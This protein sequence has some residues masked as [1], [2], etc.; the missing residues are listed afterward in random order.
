MHEKKE[1]FENNVIN[2]NN[3]NKLNNINNNNYDINNND[4][5]IINNN[6][7]YHTKNSLMK[8]KFKTSLS[9]S[10][11]SSNENEKIITQPINSEI[12]ENNI[13]N[14]N[15]EFLN[16]SNL[17]N[18]IKYNFDYEIN[19]IKINIEENS[20]SKMFYI[21]NSSQIIINYSEFK[22]NLKQSPFEPPKNSYKASCLKRKVSK[23]KIR[24]QNKDY[25]LDMTYI[26]D[27]IIAMGFPSTNCETIYRNSLNDISN[28][29]KTYHNNNVKIYN[30]CL[31]KDRI[32]PKNY[33][34]NFK[35][36]L[37]PS[38]DHNPCPVKLLLEFCLDVMI[39]LIESLNG[40]AAIHCKAG[41][42]RT[43]L[44]ICCYL[45]FSGLCENSDFAL[46]YY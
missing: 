42:G 40:I 18:Q 43:G 33:F 21:K 12:N 19:N 14:N 11:N 26:T 38:L 35:V 7:S 22:D 3:K 2:N 5:Y 39:F 44:M 23:N 30:L 36:A 29:F 10:M 17:S 45:I 9:S 31:E 13:N 46:E 41:K 25:D 32:Y 15:N 8:N 20:N 27:R 1:K 4:N 34:P 16:L 6:E 37:F 24:F 28:Y